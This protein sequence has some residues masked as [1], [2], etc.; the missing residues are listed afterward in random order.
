MTRLKAV[1]AELALEKERL[2]V[3]LESIAD[4]VISTDAEGRITFINEAAVHMTGW[5]E[6]EALGEP[7]DIVFECYAEEEPGPRTDLVAQCLAQEGVC[8][9]PGYSRLKGKNRRSRYVRE[10]A[11]PVR[12]ESGAAI[13]AVM[14]FQDATQRRLFQRRLEHS[15]THDALTGLA[16]RTAFEMQLE[17]SL[18][19]ALSG[20]GS[21]VLCLIDLDKFKAVNDGAG[22]SAGDA[23]LKQIAEVI[24]GTCRQSDFVARLGGDEFGLIL[25]NCSVKMARNVTQKIIRNIASLNFT[26]GEQTFRVGASIGITAI[27]GDVGNALELYRNADN[28]CYAAKRNGRGCEVVFG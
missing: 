21:H 18:Q 4:G 6:N 16:N 1:E 17:N 13:G 5:E 8:R 2:R 27:D 28:A 22:H 9:A 15:A 11:S 7:I 24:R 19:Q 20:L 12:S 25:N 14:V 23:L 3:T 26:W 10:I